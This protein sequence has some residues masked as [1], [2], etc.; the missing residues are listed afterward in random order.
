MSS[1]TPTRMPSQTKTP[2]RTITPTA[3]PTQTLPPT[4]SVIEQK[5]Y[6][7]ELLKT[8]ANC[9]LPCWWGILPGET[10]WE[11]AYPILGHIGSRIYNTPFSDGTV[12]HSI[13]V[14]LEGPVYNN[15]NFNSK[16]NQ[17]EYI[18]IRMEGYY[19]PAEAKKYWRSY[20][21]KQMILDYGQPTRILTMVFGSEN[22]TVFYYL[23]LFYDDQG[24]MAFYRGTARQSVLNN[25][26]TYRV[27]PVWEYPTWLPH[28]K[29]YLQSPDSLIP[30]EELAHLSSDPK[31]LEM[32]SQTTVE[33]FTTNVLTGENPP[34]FETLQSIWP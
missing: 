17:V 32:I 30:L 11:T 19:N 15:F 12:S 21:P 26:L 33:E 13:S 31:P 8:N 10:S 27:C 7:F 6:L 14:D 20:S 16:N 18:Y 22:G 9:R 4:L 2:T 25:E 23:L 28:L 1:A 34:C 24:I 3:V 29:L 5:Y